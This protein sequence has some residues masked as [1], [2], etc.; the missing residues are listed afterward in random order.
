MSKLEI[1]WTKVD[2]APALATYSLLPIVS[3]FVG[4]AGV[5][6]TLKDI[7]LSGRILANFPDKLKPEQK[8]NDEL[9]EL[10]KLAMKPE[11]NIIKL[12]NISASIPQLKAAIKELQSKGYDVPNYPDSDATPADKE[13]RA[14][15]GKV[16][17]SAV[18]PV[19]R[20]GNSDRRAAGAVKAYARSH[21]H[22]MGVW[23]KD[24]KTRVANMS[25]HDFY[26][27]EVAT[28]VAAAGAAR[29]E[30]AGSDGTV[31]VLKEKVP[32][33]AGEIIDCS[34]MNAK[35][36]RAFFAAQ[37]DAAKKDG[38]LFSLH[39]KTTMMK[40]SDPIIFGHCVSVFFAD[41]FEKHGATLKRL[42]VDPDLG[43]S[44]MMTR[45]ETLP[46]AEKAAIKADI[47][48][49]YAKRPG[50]A[51][52]NSDKG[53]TNLH[54]PSDVIID[55]SIPAMIRESGKMWGADGKLHDT[56][57][58][59]PDR[60]YSTLFQA[61]IEDCKAHGAFDPKTMGS[62]PNVGLMAQQAEEYGSHD[63]TFRMPK[64]GTV[65]VVGE[66][67]TVLMSQTVEAGDI[68]RMCQVKDEPIQDWVKLAVRRAR[69]TNT[70]AVFWLDAKRAHDAQLIAKV[71][72]YLKNEDTSGLDIRIMAPVEATKFSL[73]RIR[74]GQD[75]ISVTGNVLRDYLTDLFPIMELGT[76]A[77]MLSVVPL[78]QGGGLFETGAGGS[79]PKHAEQFKQESY[80][81]WDSLGEFLA[82][83]ASLE[84]LAQ[85]SGNKDVK[86]LAETLD[87]ANGEILEHDRS[88]A[89]KVGELDNRG[90]HFYLALYWA[91]ALARRD[92][93]SAL[94]ARFKPLAETLAAQEAKINAELLAAQGKP[95]DTGGYYLPDEKKTSAAMR[96]SKTLNDALATL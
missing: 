84:H 8:I 19:L 34:V 23:S 32:L 29:I 52:V 43:V 44:D 4:A 75:T 94:A 1:M 35:A 12:P 50:L 3:A 88:P 73:E 85:V 37:M 81:R 16:L 62:V 13:I 57:A 11:A 91:K 49:V 38:I 46:E 69:L 68:F 90:S 21:P 65:R 61:V 70:P 15:Y 51:M 71:E 26:G 64:D 5:S 74:K 78:L 2:E 82:L 60:C 72:K 36:L 79:A 53:I 96:P 86:V 92:N 24:S 31:T 7:S 17:G 41:V 6:V 87:E 27:S 67:G 77:K 9:A 30:L 48:A 95:V 89:R 83:G 66:D 58:A 40:I 18:N 39:V 45:I 56:L 10:G 59:V 25:G 20:E 22:K 80:L 47:E 93:S 55:A 76:S 33:K 28:T 54:V 42:G 63:K 14:R